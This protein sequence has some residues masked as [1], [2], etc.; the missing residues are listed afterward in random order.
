ML[1][2][3]K[4]QDLITLNTFV[5]LAPR[6]FKCSLIVLDYCLS[7]PLLQ[8][9]AMRFVILVHNEILISF[10]HAYDNAKIFS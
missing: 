3:V 7:K 5:P 9:T 8:N 1:S 2:N 10:N 4:I 6:C